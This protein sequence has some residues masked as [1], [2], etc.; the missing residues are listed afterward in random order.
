[1][2]NITEKTIMNSINRF[3]NSMTI[4]MIAH[5]LS[6]VKE[7]DTIFHLEHGKLRSKG[8]FKELSMRDKLFRDMA[9]NLL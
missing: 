3:K 5:R 7:C 1:M 2:D 8:T 4:I 6:T 9:S